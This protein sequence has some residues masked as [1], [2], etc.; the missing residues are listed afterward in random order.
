MI[1]WCNYLKIGFTY[2]L[3][4]SCS[5]NEQ[6]LLPFTP[7]ELCILPQ[8]TNKFVYPY[9]DETLIEPKLK[10]SMNTFLREIEYKKNSENEIGL[11]FFDKKD[12]FYII[13]TTKKRISFQNTIESLDT[14]N[15][16]C[17]KFNHSKFQL[18]R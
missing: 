7:I 15:G 13:R 16:F 11:I 8:Y 14:N 4:T 3:L 17:R 6:I 9:V 5:Y 18:L 12:K 1:Y 10:N 2:L